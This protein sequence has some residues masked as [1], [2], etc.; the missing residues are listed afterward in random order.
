MAG[1][2]SADTPAP[3][4][5]VP[6]GAAAY[7]LRRFGCDGQPT[8]PLLCVLRPISRSVDSLP[9]AF[10]FRALTRPAPAQR[11]QAT[12]P[13]PREPRVIELLLRYEEMQEQGQPV[14]PEELCRDSPELLDELR[15]GIANIQRLSRMREE[16]LC[17]YRWTR[18]TLVE[19]SLNS[20]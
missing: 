6:T 12:H 13:T 14:V 4:S 17:V 16:F 5:A 18:V 3:A 8:V 10:V 15:Q 7:F 11:R 19:P 20:K 1:L 9:H 2:P